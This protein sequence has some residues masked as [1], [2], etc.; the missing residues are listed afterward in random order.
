VSLSIAEIIDISKDKHR[1]LNEYLFHDYANSRKFIM[2]KIL[3]TTYTRTI[4]KFV[5]L[6]LNDSISN[7]DGK[8]P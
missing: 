1:K 8:I 3:H 7:F 5:A 6:A 2:I 4:E